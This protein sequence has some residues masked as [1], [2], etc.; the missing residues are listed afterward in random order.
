MPPSKPKPRLLLF[1]IAYYAESTL[2]AV[3]EAIPASIFGDYDAEVLVVDDGSD[4][5]TFAIGREYQASHPDVRMTVLRNEY[6]QGYGGNQKLGYSFAIRQAFDFVA[7]VHGD[8]QYAPEALPGLVAPL[9][10][11]SAAAVFGSRMLEKGAALRGGMP[12]YKYE[13]TKILTAAQNL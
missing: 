11:G 4:D 8:G 2:R 6:N 3:L 1:V 9:R 7:M 13:A 5:R 10:D 12:L